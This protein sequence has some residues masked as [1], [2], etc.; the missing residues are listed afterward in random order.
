MDRPLPD[1]GEPAGRDLLK[2]VTIRGEEHTVLQAIDRSLAHAS[3]HFGQIVYVARL[4]K[5]EG[6][7]WITVPPG[8]S[9]AQGRKYLK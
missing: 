4:V 8:Q 5:K 2:K 1:L 9:I 3:Y 6:W 7:T